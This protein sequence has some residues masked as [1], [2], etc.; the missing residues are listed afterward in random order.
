MTQLYNNTLHNWAS[1]N[2][3][4]GWRVRPILYFDNVTSAVSHHDALVTSAV[5]LGW[6]VLDV[7]R[8]SPLG[9]PFIKDMYFDAARRFPDCLFYAY[10]NGDILFNCGLADT[11]IA[12]V[13]VSSLCFFLVYVYSSLCFFLKAPGIYCQLALCFCSKQSYSQ[14]RYRM[15]VYF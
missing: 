15:L 7:P 11:L 4:C 12:V 14:R 1:V 5:H 8:S 3:T 6:T 13:K 10:I 9:L 2:E